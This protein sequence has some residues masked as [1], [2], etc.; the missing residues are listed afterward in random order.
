[1]LVHA[2]FRIEIKKLMKRRDWISIIAITAIGILFASA[3]ISG[4]YTGPRDQSALYWM[5]TQVL[6]SVVLYIVPFVCAL[7]GTRMLAT[8]LEEKT[9]KLYIERIQNRKNIYLSKVLAY[10]VYSIFAFMTTLLFQL[11][12][13]QVA[14]S[15]NSI[16]F[17]GRLFGENTEPLIVALFALWASSFYLP[18]VITL[19]LGAKYKPVTVMSL[20]MGMV[21]LFRNAYRLPILEWFNPWTYIVKLTIPYSMDTDFVVPPASYGHSL[22]CYIALIVLMT[23]ITV[24]IGIRY[25]QSHQ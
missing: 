8:E 5:V 25:F 9:L 6:N 1:M 15:E 21:F 7:I 16:Y 22:A 17:S 12:L 23:I 24:G 14:A 20:F 11:A 3:S 2:L 4:N 10:T 19:M 13:Y 18:G